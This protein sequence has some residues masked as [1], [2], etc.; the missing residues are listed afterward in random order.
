VVISSCVFTLL[1]GVLLFVGWRN[2][3]REVARCTVID[4]FTLDASSREEVEQSVLAALHTI[5]LREVVVEPPSFRRW[6]A[7]GRTG[8][9]WRSWGQWCAVFIDDEGGHYSV[10]CK[11]WPTLA[12][13][14]YDFG[15]GRDA[16]N[17]VE[18]ALD[19][20]GLVLSLQSTRRF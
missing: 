18:K 13:T 14:V 15:A 17:R 7:S 20:N 6:V 4:T 10:T 8:M 1:N 5:G 16:L 9:T 11:S 3:K 2:T 19:Q 12:R